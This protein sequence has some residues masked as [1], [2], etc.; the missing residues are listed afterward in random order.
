MTVICRTWT[1]WPPQGSSG[2]SVEGNLLPT[3]PQFNM[4]SFTL[5]NLWKSYQTMNCYPAALVGNRRRTKSVYARSQHSRR[6]QMG[7][8][9]WGGELVG[10][11]RCRVGNVN[12]RHKDDP[13]FITF[14]I[15]TNV[16]QPDWDF[17]QTYGN[18]RKLVFLKV[19]SSSTSVE[20]QFQKK[21][22]FW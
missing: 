4:L 10:G 5:S 13:D 8:T 1:I 17:F 2:T 14:W 12:N 18:C 21:D 11:P 9:N 16:G 3:W 19:C 7:K 20:E 6:R 15:L 22:M